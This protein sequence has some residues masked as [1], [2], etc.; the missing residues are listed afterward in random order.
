[1]KKQKEVPQ[2]EAEVLYRF[3]DTETLIPVTD[4]PEDWFD[5]EFPPTSGMTINWQY[6][7]KKTFW[8]W[9]RSKFNF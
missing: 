4:V 1:M 9:L 3:E 8:S 5:E 2:D 6:Q 7:E